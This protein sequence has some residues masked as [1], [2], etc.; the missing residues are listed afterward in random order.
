MKIRIPLSDAVMEDI[1]KD[2]I[3]FIREFS[4]GSIEG[5]RIKY[6]YEII[7]EFCP[8][9]L[10]PSNHEMLLSRRISYINGVP[11]FNF[12]DT[13]KTED[14]FTID[15]HNMIITPTKIDPI[16]KSMDSF[17][18][19]AG[20]GYSRSK[21][22]SVTNNSYKTLT[23]MEIWERRQ[24]TV[25]EYLQQTIKSMETR[26]TSQELERKSIRTWRDFNEIF[27]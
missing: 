18:V 23:S 5:V 4:E 17:L 6:L 11:M 16:T 1:Q 10:E 21:Y 12:L 27:R 7:R 9:Y 25:L 14:H 22:D 19:S 24:L 3:P 15:S 2:V 26:M 8:W 13:V 20:M